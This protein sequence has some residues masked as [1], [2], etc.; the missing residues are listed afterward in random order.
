LFLSIMPSTSSKNVP[1]IAR[2][3]CCLAGLLPADSVRPS[4]MATR[5]VS[6]SSSGGVVCF[7]IH[8][9]NF[10][11]A[12]LRFAFDI[13]ALGKKSGAYYF[14]ALFPL[15]RI[16]NGVALPCAVCVALCDIVPFK[17]LIPCHIAHTMSHRSYHATSFIPCHLLYDVPPCS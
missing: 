5:T 8:S 15:Y 10:L 13:P 12:S 17:L 4:R 1:P 14:M 16:A 2:A 3:S 6:S 11:M 9:Y 7:F